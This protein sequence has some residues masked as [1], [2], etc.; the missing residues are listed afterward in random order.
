[1]GLESLPIKEGEQTLE[2]IE[3]KIEEMGYKIL[4]IGCQVGRLKSNDESYVDSYGDINFCAVPMNMD[5]VD[6]TEERYCLGCKK[7]D[8]NNFLIIQ[9]DKIKKNWDVISIERNSES[10]NEDFVVS[11]EGNIF[12]SPKMNYHLLYPDNRWFWL[13]EKEEEG[14]KL[15]DDVV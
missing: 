10:E 14:E 3:K 4:N 13:G 11:M 8:E 2:R 5:L 1:M 15:I 9:H 12:W 6:Q 7:V